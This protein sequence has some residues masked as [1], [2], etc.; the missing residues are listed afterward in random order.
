MGLFKQGIFLFNNRLQ[1]ILLECS[2]DCLD[3]DR[4]ENNVIDIID[5]LNCSVQISWSDLSYKSL[6]I[7]KGELVMKCQSSIEREKKKRKGKDP[8]PKSC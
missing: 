1:I 2:S 4:R 5:S 3:R 7:K 8:S 6:F